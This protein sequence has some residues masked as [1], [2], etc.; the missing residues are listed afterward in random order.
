MDNPVTY[1][2]PVLKL[3]RKL[4]QDIL[5][6]CIFLNIINKV[7]YVLLYYLIAFKHSLLN[8]KIIIS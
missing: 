7:I 4:Q 8:R 6:Y 2:Y 3:T 1:A 5:F